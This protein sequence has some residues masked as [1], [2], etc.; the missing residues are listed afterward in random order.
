[1]WNEDRRRQDCQESVFTFL[2]KKSRKKKED[3]DKKLEE[4]HKEVDLLKGLLEKSY[5]KRLPSPK[6]KGI[7]SS[8]ASAIYHVPAH[9]K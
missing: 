2:I 4:A 5:K 7:F 9:F 6:Q 3:I 8:I 1:L